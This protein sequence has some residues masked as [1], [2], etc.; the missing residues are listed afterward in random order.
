MAA[1]RSPGGQRIAANHHQVVARGPSLLPPQ[2]TPIKPRAHCDSVIGEPTF[3]LP[4]TDSIKPE[5][6]CW[7]V[8]GRYARRV[9][10]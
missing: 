7:Q 5:T 2:T 1:H 3:R 4:T 8:R 6:G 9:A 10:A